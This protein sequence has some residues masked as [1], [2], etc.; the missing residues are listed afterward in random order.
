MEWVFAVVGVILGVVA[1][2]LVARSMGAQS[3]KN[4]AA[5]AERL[6][7]DA[8][9]KAEILQREKLIEAKDEITKLREKAEAENSA[10]L[11]K[12]REQEK[13]LNA[14]ERSLDKRS[15]SLDS[16]EHRLSSMQGQVEKRERDLEREQRALDDL[17][18]DYE[19]RLDEA[20]ERIGQINERLEQVSG[21][22]ADEA[23]EEL[24]DNLRS[25]VAME[26]AAIIRESENRTKLEADK[27]SR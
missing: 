4:T 25:E 8:R 6:L 2:V 14:R 13:S 19:D 9:E 23:K 22:T 7:N 24:L 5:E 11:D 26:S 12:T 20:E 3:V 10:R 17:K 21:M 27:K 15:D 18:R 1:G 16:R